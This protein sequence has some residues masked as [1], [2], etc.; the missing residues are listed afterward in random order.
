MSNEE[1]TPDTSAKPDRKAEYEAAKAAKAAA[2]EAKKLEKSSKPEKPS[3]AEKSSE[4]SSTE[5]SGRVG[6]RGRGSKQDA[7]DSKP[8]L[9]GLT[10]PGSSALENRREIPTSTYDL[11]NGTF[12][13]STKS[14]TTG[15]IIGGLM[16]VMVGYFLLQ[17]VAA[18][19]QGASV[20]NQIAAAAKDRQA[21]LERFGTATGLVGVSDSELIERERAYSEAL[22]KI[23]SKQPD[24]TTLL[25]EI[26]QFA[27]TGVTITSIDITRADLVPGAAEKD[28]AGA[29][30]GSAEA[31]AKASTYVLTLTGQGNDFNSVVRWSESMRGLPS[32]WDL[33]FT[34]Q[35]LGVVMVAKVRGGVPG[36]AA[37]LLSTLGIS[38]TDS[39]AGATA[40]DPT[41]VDGQVDPTAGSGEQA[42]TGTGTQEGTNTGA[43]TGTNP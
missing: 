34:R 8:S 40:G 4:P 17:G 43:T 35:G 23:I 42:A 5:S 15:L 10:T 33:T 7:T 32:L 28:A 41:A 27:G 3:K 31:L 38:V 21:I 13:A 26:R 12:G 6:R 19:F 20:D 16:L 39:A 29:T 22:G 14:R 1:V 11:L 24:V 37:N 18:T 9:P 30:P 36:P 2:K 25:S